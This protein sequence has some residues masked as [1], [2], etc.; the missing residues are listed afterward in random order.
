M[1]EQ[2]KI[3]WAVLY[4]E[5][6]RMYQD[7]V[8][9]EKL[10]TLQL[11]ADSLKLLD[12]ASTLSLGGASIDLQPPQLPLQAIM[13]QVVRECKAEPKAYYLQPKAVSLKFNKPHCEAKVPF[14]SAKLV[15]AF[16]EALETH[17]RLSFETA[18]QFLHKYAAHLP[19]PVPAYRD[20]SLYDHIKSTAGIA[21]SLY[22]EKLFQD[23]QAAIAR[24]SS[25]PLCLIGGDLSGIQ[26]YIY[27]I[28]SKNAAKNLKGRSFFLSLLVESIIE[29]L[30]DAL[31]LNSSHIVYASGGG[32]Y[33]LAPHY[34]TLPGPDGTPSP[35]DEVLRKVQD[36]IYAEYQMKFFFA[37]DQVPVSEEILYARSAEKNISTLWTDLHQQLNAKKRRRHHENLTAE[38][39]MYFQPS[40]LGGTYQR[41][42]VTNEEFSPKEQEELELL[43]AQQRGAGRDVRF[44]TFEKDPISGNI[45][46]EN[47]IRQSTFLPIQLG[48]ALRDAQVWIACKG[49]LKTDQL[50]G[51]QLIR[52][53]MYHYF[54]DKNEYQKHQSV[55]QQHRGKLILRTINESNFESFIYPNSR[56]HFGFYFYGGNKFPEDPL[57]P[58]YPRDTEQLVAQ[59]WSGKKHTADLGFQRVGLLRMDIDNLGEIIRSGFADERKT[60]ARFSCLSRSLDYFFKGYLNKIL[61]P[62]VEKS[63]TAYIIYSGGDDLFLLGRWDHAIKIAG[64][65]RKKFKQYCGHNPYLTLS[66]GISIHTPKFPIMLGAKLAGEQEDEAKSYRFQTG[67][68]TWEK[69]AFCLFGT[70]L[71][72]DQEYPLVRK[73]MKQLKKMLPEAGSSGDTGPK[74]PLREGLIHKIHQHYRAQQHQQKHGLTQKWYWTY[75]YD[76]SRIERR[77][78]AGSNKARKAQKF[79]RQIKMDGVA[80]SYD[81][82]KLPGHYPYL[83]LLDLAAQ[84]ADFARRTL[85]LKEP[86]HLKS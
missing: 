60:F 52:E 66:G 8:T 63:H 59:Q 36:M 34:L 32:F 47:P 3:Y 77:I 74:A 83:R 84:W 21:A 10:S 15:Q 48:K 7:D 76:L 19:I 80:N 44:L 79:I 39:A 31:E 23:K 51:F 17:G 38:F 33:I 42:A 71:N 61:K 14:Q 46:Q 49:K 70:P 25:P 65:I 85:E 75:V 43:L 81:G 64:K 9:N 54:L 69:N 24:E 5:W 11:E 62:Y 12:K 22:K 6:G 35:L 73:L 82:L 40:Q 58:E 13:S 28:V 56:H 67:I 16:W 4:R 18:L 41:D 72:W 26:R 30:L 50:K 2:E 29:Y 20:V 27:D 53:G 1:T 68:Q 86:K 45:I 78:P 37:L 55:L 57:N